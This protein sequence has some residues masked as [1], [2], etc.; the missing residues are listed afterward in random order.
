M[1]YDPPHAKHIQAQVAVVALVVTGLADTVAND[2][3]VKAGTS[4]V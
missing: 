1:F 4:M 2:L 3:V